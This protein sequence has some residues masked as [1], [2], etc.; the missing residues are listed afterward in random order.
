MKKAYDYIDTISIINIVF[1]ITI[2][3]PTYSKG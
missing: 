2:K 3:H 1:N